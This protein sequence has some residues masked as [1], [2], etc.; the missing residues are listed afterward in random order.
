MKITRYA[1]AAA[2]GLVGFLAPPVTMMA[3]VIT[4]DE[5]KEGAPP[6][7]TAG[8][9]DMGFSASVSLDGETVS[10][11]GSYTLCSAVAAPGFACGPIGSFLGANTFLMEP[12]NSPTFGLVSD[13]WQVSGSAA[14]VSTNCL[15]FPPNNLTLCNDQ[16]VVTI[17]GNFTSDSDTGSLGVPS[18]PI[19][20][21]TGFLEPVATGSIPDL[22]ALVASDVSDAPEPSSLLLLGTGILG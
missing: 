4:I 14:V 5:S 1:L 21:E 3:G 8:G 2:I 13:I 12:P 9:F 17:R 22:N 7:I 20:V 11:S 15:T 6:I 19:E 18:G 10:F 16:T